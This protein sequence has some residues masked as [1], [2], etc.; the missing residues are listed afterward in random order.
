MVLALK[1]NTFKDEACKYLSYFGSYTDRNNL[2]DS[3]YIVSKTLSGFYARG[4]QNCFLKLQNTA[5]L[6]FQNA[7]P[8]HSSFI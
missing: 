2:K 1:L 4:V 8:L 5:K 6:N 3:Y 7:K